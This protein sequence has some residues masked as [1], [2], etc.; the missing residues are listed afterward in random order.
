MS[1]PAPLLRHTSGWDTIPGQG[2]RVILR[3]DGCAATHLVGPKSPDLQRLLLARARLTRHFWHHLMAWLMR[4]YHGTS[5]CKRMRLGQPSE[6]PS[7]A[8]PTCTPLRNRTRARADRLNA[9]TEPLRPDGVACSCHSRLGVSYGTG[10]ADIRPLRLS[11][12]LTNPRTQLFHHGRPWRP[13]SHAGAYDSNNIFL[14]TIP[15][16]FV[17]YFGYTSGLGDPSGQT[18]QVKLTLTRSD[19]TRYA[20]WTIMSMS[21][22][23]APDQGAYRASAS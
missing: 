5:T 3:C 16:F 18:P 23:D 22:V 20:P 19:V 6:A 1:G 12:G 11:Y 17:L 14:V 8:G 15:G 7:A 2:G 4:T 10:Q 9:T 13:M 21:A